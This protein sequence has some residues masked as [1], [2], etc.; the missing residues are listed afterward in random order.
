MLYKIKSLNQKINGL[1]ITPGEG[2]LFINK[3]DHISFGLNT[4]TYR[5]KYVTH[6]I[7]KSGFYMETEVFLNR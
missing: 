5:V 1:V 7:D 6:L 3:D 2:Q 4:V